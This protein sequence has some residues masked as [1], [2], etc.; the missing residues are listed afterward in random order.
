MTIRDKDGNVIRAEVDPVDRVLFN[1]GATTRY[2]VTG[3]ERGSL[4]ALKAAKGG[5]G[6]EGMHWRFELPISSR[7]RKD[8]QGDVFA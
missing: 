2:G 8:H 6:L 4:F 3:R 1:A 5:A 7:A